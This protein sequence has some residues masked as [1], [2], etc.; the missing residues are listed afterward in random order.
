MKHNYNYEIIITIK[1]QLA[2]LQ[3]NNVHFPPVN[4]S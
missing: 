2:H 3:W 4:V 1:L